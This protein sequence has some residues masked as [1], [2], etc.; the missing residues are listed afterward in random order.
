M[1]GP[2]GFRPR[3]GGLIT[4]GSTGIVIASAKRGQRRGASRTPAPGTIPSQGTIG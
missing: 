3:P 1:P 2:G 4:A